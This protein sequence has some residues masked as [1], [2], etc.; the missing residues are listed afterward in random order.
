MTA[1][2]RTFVSIALFL[3]LAAILLATF[4]CL[5]APVG[6]P[7]TSKVDEALTGVYRGGDA[8]QTILA[9]LRPWDAK[10]YLLT[11]MAVEKKDDKE[12]HAEMHFKAWLTSL[13]GQTFLTA[14]PMDDLS[15]ILHTDNPEKKYWAV[16]RLDKTP[17]GLVAS[18]I[19]PD[20]DFV[21]GLD[22]RDQLEAAIKAHVN[23]KDLYGDP[24]T[25]K[26][27]GKEDQPFIEEIMG[28]FN[29]K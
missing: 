4:A 10:T 20:S 16:F 25:F 29:T 2:S 26:T 21:K 17:T 15:D 6:D 5:P 11:Y 28:K 7:E 8:Q 12:S 27:L 14:Q 3:P 19:K 23:D 9:V 22:T 1:K 18:M 24:M 13:G